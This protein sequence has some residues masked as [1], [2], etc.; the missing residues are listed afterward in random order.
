MSSEDSFDYIGKTCGECAYLTAQSKIKYHEL[1]EAD[2]GLCR[3]YIL[4]NNFAVM[5]KNE[6]AC[7]EFMPNDS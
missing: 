4:K 3:Y 5:L 6:I 1:T 7:P 2:S